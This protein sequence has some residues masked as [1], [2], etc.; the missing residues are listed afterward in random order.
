LIALTHFLAE[1]AA[2]DDTLAIGRGSREIRQTK[3]KIWKLKPSERFKKST[4]FC[5]RF[6]SNKSMSSKY[7]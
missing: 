2:E 3:S 1:R 7:G 6:R 5:Q 4:Q